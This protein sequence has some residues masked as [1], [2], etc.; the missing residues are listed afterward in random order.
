[1]IYRF[2]HRN[3][4][5]ESCIYLHRRV[6]CRSYGVW[7]RI[8]SALISGRGGGSELGPNNPSDQKVGTCEPS[9]RPEDE[10]EDLYRGLEADK[11]ER[12]RVTLE[13]GVKESELRMRQQRK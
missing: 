1:M 2:Y 10:N 5:V 6:A 8:R 4:L 9:S 11:E 13:E 3:C 7:G 12:I